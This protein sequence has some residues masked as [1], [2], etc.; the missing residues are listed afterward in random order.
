MATHVLVKLALLKV[1][2]KLNANEEKISCSSGQ[3]SSIC[4]Q[5]FTL[6]NFVLA[7][8][9]QCVERCTEQSRGQVGGDGMDTPIS[10]LI[11]VAL[12]GTEPGISFN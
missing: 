3:I 2:D 12:H 6:T 8:H 4:S 1:T 9:G 11:P 10:S 5:Y 7:Y